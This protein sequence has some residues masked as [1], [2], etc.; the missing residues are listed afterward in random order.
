MLPEPSQHSHSEQPRCWVVIPAA[1]VGRRFGADM[2]KQYLELAG[3]RIIDYVLELFLQHEQIA[4]CVVALD[5]ADP[6]WSGCQYAQHP[7]VWRAPGG[8]ERCHSVRNALTVLTEFA[9][10]DDW[11]FVHDAARPCLRHSDIDAL[12]QVLEHESVGALLAVPIH[13][14]VKQS[15]EQQ[16]RIEKTVPR[17]NLW[18]AYTPQVFQLAVLQHALDSALSHG[19]AITDDASAVELLGLSP[20]LVEGQADNIKITQKS[21]LAL[22]Q[23]FLMQQGRLC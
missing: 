14:T 12:L 7:Q 8:C 13:D 5:P 18:R 17:A 15:A 1:G 4:G 22:A 11:V 23:F 9:Q 19:H 10:P 3:K 6:Y 21:D 2:P 16:P 20:L